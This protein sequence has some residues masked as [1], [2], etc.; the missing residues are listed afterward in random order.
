MNRLATFALLGVLSVLPSSAQVNQADSQTLQAIL[1]EVRAVHNEL[2]LSQTSQLLLTELGIQQTA[3]SRDI[4]R[5]DD[6]RS[7]LSQVQASQRDVAH[8]LAP[9]QENPEW[10][11]T[12]AEKKDLADLKQELE[13]SLA[14][15]KSQELERSSDLQDAEN[16]LRREQVTLDNIQS[17]LNDIVKKLEPVSS[18]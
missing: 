10:G 11:A 1:T 2:R 16:S 15:L 17:Q 7:K 4:L 14:S 5:R 12:P 6:L 18:Q 3:V 13:H 8:R 9:I